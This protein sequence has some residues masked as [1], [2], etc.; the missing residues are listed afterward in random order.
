MLEDELLKIGFILGSPAA[1]ARI[2]RKYADALKTL[3]MVLLN[4]GLSLCSLPVEDL[5]NLQGRSEEDLGEKAIN[6]TLA[7]G[8]RV[9]QADA[10][11]G[12]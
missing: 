6:D 1:L 5:W 3:A 8:Y 2:Y 9:M 7:Q 11:P 12:P 10:D 4:G